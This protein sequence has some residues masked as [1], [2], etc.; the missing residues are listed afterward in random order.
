MAFTERFGLPRPLMNT[1]VAW[2]E[3]DA[4]FPV[5]RVIVELDGYAFHSSRESFRENRE[6]DT[7]M[8]ARGLVT[9]RITWDRLNDAPAREAATRTT[10]T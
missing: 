2:R 4:F 6:R 9:V 1:R 7:E 3:V 5:E 8:L 10:S